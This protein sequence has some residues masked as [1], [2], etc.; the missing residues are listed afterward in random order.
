MDEI[1]MKYVSQYL[2]TRSPYY[3]VLEIEL[4][5]RG[6]QG[7]GSYIVI[8][9]QKVVLKMQRRVIYYKSELRMSTERLVENLIYVNIWFRF[10]NSQK[11]NFCKASL[12]PKQNYNVLSP[13]LN[14]QYLWAIYIFPIP[15]SVC[16]FC[17][18]QI[19]RRILGIYKIA[20]RYMNAGFGN[21]PRCF[22]SGILDFWYSVGKTWIW[23]TGG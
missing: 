8:L 22:I 9:E 2:Y 16:L 11:R 21:E 10:M 23:I 12:F 5:A 14:I 7:E 6:W 18:S 15:G 17:C 19:G 1:W 4:S 13:N 20:H 3:L